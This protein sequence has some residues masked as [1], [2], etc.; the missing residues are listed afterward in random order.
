MKN[1]QASN[2]KLSEYWHDIHALEQVPALWRHSQ[3]EC[4]KLQQKPCIEM[5][6]ICVDRDVESLPWSRYPPRVQ[7][8]LCRAHKLGA[9]VQVSSDGY[10]PRARVNLAMG[11]AALH[12]AQLLQVG[13]IHSISGW[14][15]MSPQLIW[16][17]LD[18]FL[19]LCHV[20]K[21]CQSSAHKLHNHYTWNKFECFV[22]FCIFFL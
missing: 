13:A 12:I 11:L 16:K 3:F 10:L 2:P 5:M 17:A 22:T 4:V 8:L 6:C 14:I 7:S 21:S 20:L 18:L 19:L 9:L 1:C 15:Y